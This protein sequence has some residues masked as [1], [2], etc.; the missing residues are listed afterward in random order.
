M[1]LLVLNVNKSVVSNRK[2]NMK[3]KRPSD[4]EWVKYFKESDEKDRQLLKESEDRAQ[5]REE[6]VI[7]LL[8]T[9]V[10]FTTRNQN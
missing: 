10:N 9:L 5:Q 6:I 1:N 7:N 8:E 2:E 4:Y 3:R